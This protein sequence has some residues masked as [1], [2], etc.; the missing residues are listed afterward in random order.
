VGSLPLPRAS[1]VANA[2]AYYNQYLYAKA[3]II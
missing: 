2:L 1:L 3:V